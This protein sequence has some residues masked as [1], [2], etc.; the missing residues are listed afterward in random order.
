MMH[1][2]FLIYKAQLL[3]TLSTGKQRKNK[4]AK[5]TS[6]TGYVFLWLFLAA[7]AAIYEYAYSTMFAAAGAVEQFPGLI[8]FAASALTLLSS[9]AYTKTLI[10]NSKDYDLLF[11]LPVKGSTIVAAKLATLYTLDLAVSLALLLPC[12]ILYA[13]LAAPPV[14]FYVLYFFLMLASPMLPILIAA[15]LSALISLFASRF[16]YSRIVGAVIYIAL[17]GAYMIAVMNI[18][19]SSAGEDSILAF[20]S[21]T[22]SMKSIYPPI[23]WFEKAFLGDIWMFL[24]FV[25]LSVLAFLVL[26]LVFGK[27]YGQIHGIFSARAHRSKYRISD[28]SASA[29]RAL[30]KKEWTRFTSSA[31]VM[32]NQASGVVAVLVFSGLIAYKVA[33]ETWGEDDM[34]RQLIATALP[35]FFAMFVALSGTASSCISLEGKNMWLLKSLPISAKTVLKAKLLMHLLVCIPIPAVCCLVLSV[36]MRLTVGQTVLMVLIPALYAYNAGVAG[37]LLNLKKPRFDWVNEIMVAK[38]SMPVTVTIFS[39]MF[40][41]MIPLV[42]SVVIAVIFMETAM[43]TLATLG[44]GLVIVVLA[45]IPAVIFTSILAKKGEGMIRSIEP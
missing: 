29:F 4:V 19:Q 27:F 38:Q 45:L 41:A 39:G 10:F 6:A 28:A 31:G 12:G 34:V 22:A 5:A 25:G 8:V 20:T 30:L 3:S 21:L 2:F 16:R 36:V 42:I 32:I 15:L 40:L 26:A 23:A 14:Y 13:V 11:S 43:A 17:F 18:S 9:I 37:M 7:I 24:L 35:Y 44:F 33:T 1:N